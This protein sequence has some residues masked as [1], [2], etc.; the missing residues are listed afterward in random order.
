MYSDV[1]MEVPKSFFEKKIDEMKE[2]KGVTF[3]TE[4]TAE[5]LKELAEQFKAIYKDAMN[6]ACALI[7]YSPKIPFAPVDGLRVNATPV[8]DVS[9]L[10]PNTIVCTLTA[11]PQ[12]PGISFIRL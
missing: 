3:D 7:R 2:A 5:D 1:V 12:S 9:P 6:G 8:P 10:L 4:L 11:V